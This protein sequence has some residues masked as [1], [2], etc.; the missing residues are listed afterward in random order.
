VCVREN[1]IGNRWKNSNIFSKPHRVM[2]DWM[3]G[4]SKKLGKIILECK[5]LDI[6]RAKA[7]S[8]KSFLAS[9]LNLAN[10]WHNWSNRFRKFIE[11]ISTVHRK[12]FWVIHFQSSASYCLFLKSHSFWN[13]SHPGH[14]Q[15][16]KSPKK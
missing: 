15:W 7:S 10:V 9:L 4:D 1:E 16:A 8:R 3:I 12:Q 6:I 5:K 13:K 11:T 2:F 14:S